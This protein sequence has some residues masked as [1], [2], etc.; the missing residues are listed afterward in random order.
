MKR[1]A[2][3]RLALQQ[4]ESGQNNWRCVL[5]VGGLGLF[6]AVLMVLAT[7]WGI[8]VEADSVF[9][10]GSARRLLE[11]PRLSSIPW[12]L[13]SAHHAPLYPTVLGVFEWLGIDA[14]LGARWL[15]A[16][17]FAA[18]VV[19]VGITFHDLFPSS[20]WHA[21]ALGTF[22]LVTSFPVLRI[23][24]CALTEPAFV[25]FYLLGFL[26]LARYLE[27]GAR[28]YLFLGSAAASLAFLTRYVGA[29]MVGVAI[30]SILGPN[31]RLPRT[32]VSDAGIFAAITCL[33]MCLWILRNI[34][35]AGTAV[36]RV[37][38]L[39]PIGEDKLRQLGVTLATWLLP[40]L[41]PSLRLGMA[42]AAYVPTAVA[43]LLVRRPAS[44]MRTGKEVPRLLPLHGAFIPAYL[45]FVAISI[46]LFD[47]HTPLDHRILLPV[48]LSGFVIFVYL[49]IRSIF[50]N[51]ESRQSL[52]ALLF[53]PVFMLHVLR[54]VTLLVEGYTMGYGYT[55]RA[56]RSSP[57]LAHVRE[58][59]VDIPIYTNGPDVIYIHTGRNANWIPYSVHL[60]ENTPNET[61]AQ[62]VASMIADVTANEGVIVYFDKITWRWYLPEEEELL[63]R[64]PLRIATA[65]DDGRIYDM[66]R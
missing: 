33:P 21:C 43:V 32:R 14:L 2:V 9:F 41:I 10:I 40:E 54:G 8:G 51:L 7:R 23:F 42:A 28:R 61:F 35:V 15:G 5:S 37:L 60:T 50:E 46:S 44:L 34:I 64:Y 49:I 16:G 11:T 63:P 3:S 56:W 47:A 58:L 24:R 19:T 29:V 36:N 55:S 26:F 59:P 20:S 13:V 65:A 52:L 1:F 18:T 38:V 12:Y 45:G 62:D 48:Y 30:L 53:L 22:L 66:R 6:A 25:L 31:R 27:G 4:P 39:H 57:I 17:I